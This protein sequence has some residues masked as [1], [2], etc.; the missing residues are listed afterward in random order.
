MSDKQIDQSYVIPEIR[1]WP[2]YKLANDRE[3]FIKEVTEFTV[4]RIKQTRKDKLSEE[5]AKVIYLERIRTKEQ[6]WRVDPPHEINYW[7]RLHRQ[8][9]KKSLDKGA[10][11]AAGNNDE[12]LRSIAERYAEE[13]AGDFKTGTYQF[14]RRFLTSGLNRLLNT[15]SNRNLKRIFSA[16]YKVRERLKIHGELELIR[17][18]TTKGNIILVPTHFSNLDS[19][20]LGW[21]ADSIGLP[22][23]SYGAGLNLFNTGILAYFMNR[24]GAYKLDRRKKNAIYLE[25]L[26]A[27]SNLSVQRGVQSLFFPGGTRER[28]G[29]I[30]K[31]LKMGLLGTVTEAQRSLYQQGKEDKLF[32]VPIVIGYNFVLE[33]ESLIG[34]YLKKTGKELYVSERT[35]TSVWGILKFLWKFFSASSEIQLSFG[36]PFDV[37][38]NFVNEKGESLDSRGNV[39]CVKEYFQSNGVISTNLQRDMEYTK[40]LADKIIERFHKENIV[41]SSHIVAFTAFNILKARNPNLDLYGVLRIPPEERVISKDDFFNA[42]KA[43]LDL[44]EIM[45]KE[46]RLKITETIRS[47]DVNKIVSNGI[48]NMGI[49]HPKAPLTYNQE[50]NLFSEHLQL[51]F[52]YHNRLLGYNLAS[53]IRWA[54]F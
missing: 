21:A 4:A 23:F 6:P 24:L 41:L 16:R 46:E 36:K 22:A 51:L 18:L 47:R 10:E 50:G 32:I 27:F 5:L 11:I 54:D 38:G 48:K 9:V 35:G 31:K 34:D 37:L 26:K 7:N 12:I 15:A 39:V 33:A 28:S 8:L 40:I 1:D 2:I 14:A 29:T 3:N 49:Y 17:T 52:Y 45:E 53:K 25:T 13:I 42:V 43:L 30:E 19:I 44:L 20:M